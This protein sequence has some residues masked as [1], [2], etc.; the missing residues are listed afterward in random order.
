MQA[1]F[2]QNPKP[3]NQLKNSVRVICAMAHKGGSSS[4][5]QALDGSGLGRT[6]RS[7]LSPDEADEKLKCRKKPGG[8]RC[9]SAVRSTAGKMLDGKKWLSCPGLCDMSCKSSF[10]IK[11]GQTIPPMSWI[12]GRAFQDVVM[13]CYLLNSG[14]PQHGYLKGQA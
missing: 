7:L 14:I 12:I 10:P 8:N 1:V 5:N 4:M 11:C 9:S 13:I 2:L 6:R 3:R